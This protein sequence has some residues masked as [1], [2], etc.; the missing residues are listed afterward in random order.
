MNIGLSLIALGYV[1]G[2][3]FEVIDH[4]DGA[5][6]VLDWR[7]A[8]PPP[9]ADALSAG[10]A[11]HQATAYQADRRS[12]YPPVGD[13]LDALAKGFAALRES[14]AMLP[15]DTLAWLDA[16]TAVKETH[17]KPAALQPAAE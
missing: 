16:V 12:A 14:G 11:A 8:T 13:Q 9:T 10:W 17:P 4:G 5:G 7:A 1:P 6:P 15:S 2:R 3:D